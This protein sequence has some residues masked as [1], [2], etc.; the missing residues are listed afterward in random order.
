[1]IKSG[2]SGRARQG[3]RSLVEQGLFWAGKAR[4]RALSWSFGLF[5]KKY[6]HYFA[7]FKDFAII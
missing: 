4:W 1:M 3:I 7:I 6:L 5:L 2:Q